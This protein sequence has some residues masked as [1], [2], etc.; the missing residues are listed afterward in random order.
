MKKLFRTLSGAVT[1]VV[2]LTE[3]VAFAG[4]GDKYTTRLIHS[5]TFDQD[6]S[7]AK[8]FEP[9]DSDNDG[10]I[11]QRDN[12]PDTPKNSTVDSDGCPEPC[13]ELTNC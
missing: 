9:Q 1:A 3:L 13:K 7:Y 11:D 8:V 12:C 10:V 2:L 4:D 5:E 6:T